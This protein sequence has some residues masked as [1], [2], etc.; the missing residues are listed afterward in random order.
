MENLTLNAGMLDDFKKYT[1]NRINTSSCKEYKYIN[2]DN[3]NFLFDYF[4]SHKLTVTDNA[5]CWIISNGKKD[6]ISY[7]F[8]GKDVNHRFTDNEEMVDKL[9]HELFCKIEWIT[10]SN[11]ETFYQDI[12]KQYLGNKVYNQMVK[13]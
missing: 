9:Y 3:I 13:L 10:R 11:A 6:M 4:V 5:S 12:V 7:G 1:K 2:N 8:S